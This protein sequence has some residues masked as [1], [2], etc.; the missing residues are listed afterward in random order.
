MRLYFAPTKPQ[1]Y[2]PKQKALLYIIYKYKHL[3][4]HIYKYTN[5]KLF[6]NQYTSDKSTS[7][8]KFPNIFQK[9]KKGGV[10]N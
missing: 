3:I 4:Y 5:Y 10:M 8:N 7:D 9:N 6:N 1:K 2:P